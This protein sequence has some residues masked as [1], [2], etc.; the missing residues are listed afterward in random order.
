VNQTG[1][2]DPKYD[3]DFFKANRMPASPKR[4]KLLQKAES[5]LLKEAPMAPIYTYV[6][7]GFLRPEVKGFPPNKVD[8]PFVKYIYKVLPAKH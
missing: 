3:A 6:N 7:F 1:W 2:K 8:R 4:L 5:I